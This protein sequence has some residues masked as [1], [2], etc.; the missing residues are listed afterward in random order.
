M[1]TLYRNIR[2]GRNILKR[3]FLGVFSVLLTIQIHAQLIVENTLT[4][5]Q[6]VQ[7]VLI[8]SGVTAFNITFTG[9]EDR[10]L[11]S[12]SRGHSTNLGLD[13]GVVMS[14]GR[15]LEIPG[16]VSF[17]ASTGNGVPGDPDLTALAGVNTNDAAV[18]EF[19][20]IPQSDTLTFN[21]VFGSEEYP[22][23]VC[24]G[25][26]DVFGFF[27]WGENPVNGLDYGGINIALIPDS[28]SLPVAINS[29]NN[30]NVG[31]FGSPGNCISLEYAEYYIDNELLGG[32]DIVF[33]GFTTVLTATLIVVPCQVYHIKLAVAD[34]GDSSYDSGVFLEANSFSAQGLN[35]S[36]NFSQSSDDFG[37][38]VEGCNN[39]TVVFELQEAQPEDYVI[40]FLTSGT[41]INGVDYS[42]IPDSIVIP[43]GQLKDSL[44]ITAFQD[45][46]PESTENL[47]LEYFYE[48]ACDDE[49]DTLEFNILD[50]SLDFTGLDSI[51]CE[52]DP[53]V[54]LT[55][56]PPEGIFSGNGITGNFFDPAAAT[57]GTDTVYYTYYYIDTTQIPQ[58][59]ICDNQVSQA[60][61]VVNDPVADAGSDESVCQGFVFDFAGST[62]VP[63]AIDF[64]S[65][66]W[67]GGAGFFSDPGIVIPVY[68]SDPLESGPVTLTMVA[69]GGFPCGNDTSSMILT[70][71]TVPVSSFT[72][73]PTDTCCTLEQVTLN[74]SSSTAIQDWNWDFGDGNTGSGQNV[75]H[76][77]TQAGTYTITLSTLTSFGCGDTVSMTYTAIAVDADFSINNDP[78]CEDY[79]VFF[80][81]S[82]NYTFT[83]WQYDF[84]DGN[85]AIGK[86]V[87]HT[88]STAGTYDVTLIVCTDT[89]V[90]QILVN[91]PAEADAGSDEATCEDVFFDLS[92]SVTPPAASNYSSVLWYG[93]DGSFNDPTLVT[94][95]Y[96]P[97]PDELGIITLTMVAYGLSPC[98]NDTSTMTLNIIPGAY[99]FAGSDENSCQGDPYDFA[100]SSV[101]PFS[102]N[103]IFIEWS[104]GAG[105]FV[106]PNVQVPVYIPAPDELGPI[107]LTVLATN[108]LNC[109]SI[110]QMVLTIYPKF[111][112]TNDVTICYGDSMFLQGN[113]RYGSG[114]YFDTVMSVNNCDSAI[115]TNLTVLPQIDM[116]FTI[117]PRDTSCLGDTAY[118]TQVGTANLTSWIWDFGDGTTST[119]PNPSH[120]YQ[121]PGTYTVTFSYTDDVGCSDEV[122]RI[123][124]AFE[125]PDVDFV[126]S[127]SSACINATV[128]FHGN[129]NANIVEWLWDF[130]DGS[131]GSG[132]D[133]THVYHNAFGHIP[134]NLEVIDN[135][136]CTNNVTRNIFISSPPDA[137]FDYYILSCDTLQFIDL[138]TAPPGFFLV[139]WQWDFGDGGTSNLQNPVHDYNAGG[140]YNVQL[141]VTADSAGLLCNDTITHPVI[142]PS[143]P[144]VY[145]TWA[146]DPTCLG[147]PTYFYGTS[148]S[149]IASWMW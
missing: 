13:E 63:S 129:S 60:V 127:M 114:T 76:V 53:A 122:T 8:G 17:F 66:K 3:T 147:D 120:A 64:D 35:T 137:D 91:P 93:G 85:T 68:H 72:I 119:E 117:S 57:I 107:T 30:G 131:I 50:Y 34:G 97:G 141:V 106:D 33:D 90:H 4:P 46:L 146:P 19:D 23:Y 134:V 94:P 133:V 42:T 82:G 75:T 5:E 124:H 39:V 112:T 59:T 110:D 49:S 38:M 40:T 87:S 135:H 2:F 132:K 28:D 109:D 79:E 9:R 96:T 148:G 37:A 65:I 89:T 56:Y 29:V 61:T 71:N 21:Y 31:A 73:F 67:Y 98:A 43:S 36:A 70:V 126:I 139:Q 142:V 14:S 140:V 74:A 83:D 84:G 62:I 6:L 108:I 118:F 12:F 145:F 1:F 88:Y 15:V 100:N 45:D 143:L 149:P 104:G 10:A 81:G 78:T 41:A 136:G 80:S 111:T 32:V 22:E 130:G 25:F 11:G 47:I 51:Y 128:T 125:P 138:S 123:V 86:N 105:S 26:N 101:V 58:D 77:Y 121:N 20:F 102:T 144:T 18:I 44:V 7:E 24:S 99:A 113:W 116:D 16:P 55:G 92:T 115:I 52:S 69:Y 103:Y 27:I 48:S 95:I 54:M